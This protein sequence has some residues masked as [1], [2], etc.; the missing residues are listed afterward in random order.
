M[1]PFF[2]RSKQWVEACDRN[3][4]SDKTPIELFNSYRVCAMHFTDSM[5][6]NDL[7]NR[8]QPNSI[9]VQGGQVEPHDDLEKIKKKHTKL[10]EIVK[11]NLQSKRTKF[12]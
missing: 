8:L 6:L 12:L 9:P 7:R 11:D 1:T 3:D 10:A 2:C 4:L 5:F